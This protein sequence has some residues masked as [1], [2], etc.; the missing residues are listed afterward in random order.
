MK[1]Q[2][3]LHL[4]L[5][6]ILQPYH[7]PPPPPPPVSNSL[8]IHLMPAPVC[9]LL[10]CTPVLFKVLLLFTVTF[11]YYLC[12][13]YY[14]PITVQYFIDHCVSWV[15]R[16]TWFNLKKK[17]LD[18][19][20]VLSEWNSFICRRLTVYHFINSLSYLKVE[21]FSLPAT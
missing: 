13:K 3:A 11:M 19:M 8:L 4:L 18:L 16:L 2:L 7:L 17:Q 20:N 5:L 15:P 14:K 9:Q 6:I 1:S 12:E 21:S 10:Y